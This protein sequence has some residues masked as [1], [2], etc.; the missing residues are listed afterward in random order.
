MQKLNVGK[1]I[2]D[3]EAP[4][5]SKGSEG[6]DVLLLQD[7]LMRKGFLKDKADGIF[8]PKTHEALKSAQIACG[9]HADG[10]STEGVITEIDELPDA[11]KS[12]RDPGQ[13]LLWCPFAVHVAPAFLDDADVK[14]LGRRKAWFYPQ[15]YPEY[16]VVHTT[17][18]G[19]NPLNVLQWLRQN[20][21]I[22][23]VIAPDGT[24]Y[25]TTPLSIGGPHTGTKHHAVSRGIE[26][27][28]WGLL[29]NKVRMS[30]GKFWPASWTKRPVN[31]AETRT[32]PARHNMRAGT[33]QCM[34]EAQEESLVE[35]LLWLESNNEIF[36]AERSVGHDEI[37]DDKSDPGG[38]MSMTMTELRALLKERSRD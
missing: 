9:V 31:P 17:A 18:S 36:Q 5:L 11:R 2:E 32:V 21:Y 14:R 27:V 25:Q 34:T 37:R 7:L 24:I 1:I 19:P 26:V 28:S 23:D 16:A 15:G 38:A 3:F 22:C 33:Y 35:Y 10:I 8:G 4:I 29:D 13:K 6:P 12:I 30:D 20:L